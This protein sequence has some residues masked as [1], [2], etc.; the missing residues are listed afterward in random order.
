M[1]PGSNLPSAAKEVY[2][3]HGRAEL[4]IER[5]HWSTS[6]RVVLHMFFFLYEPLHDYCWMPASP[7]YDSHLKRWTWN[8]ETIKQWKLLHMLEFLA[9]S[10]FCIRLRAQLRQLPRTSLWKLVNE[11]WSTR[12]RI[13]DGLTSVETETAVLP[14]RF[15][16]G[17]KCRQKYFLA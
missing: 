11:V 5:R 16:S 1:K 3:H 14:G 7:C 6:A 4:S 10:W 15:R 9:L 17:G 13:Q 8:N 2:P 12:Q